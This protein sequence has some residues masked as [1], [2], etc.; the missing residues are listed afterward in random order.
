MCWFHRWTEWSEP[1]E[2]KNHYLLQQERVCTRCKEVKR[3]DVGYSR[4]NHVTTTEKVD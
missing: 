4:A 2:V 3:R 1:F